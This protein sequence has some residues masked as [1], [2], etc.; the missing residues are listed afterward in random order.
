MLPCNASVEQ[1]ALENDHIEAVRK[2]LENNQAE[3]AENDADEP[4][5]QQQDMC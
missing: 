1:E 5:V 3:R 4:L 2:I